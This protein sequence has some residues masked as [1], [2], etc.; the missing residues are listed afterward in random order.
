MLRGLFALL[1]GAVVS[2]SAHAAA[3]GDVLRTSEPSEPVK[4]LTVDGRECNFPFRVGVHSEQE[5]DC[6]SYMSSST[7]WC[8][9]KDGSWGVC[10]PVGGLPVSFQLMLAAQTS[11]EAN[12]DDVGRM[13]EGWSSSLGPTGTVVTPLGRA[14]QAEPRFEALGGQVYTLEQCS[15]ARVTCIN[16]FNVQ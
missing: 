2:N 7:E 16:Y 3:E 11:V 12:D 8:R 13:W 6:V 9:D 14:V 1:L 5:Y 4:R 10:L 15:G